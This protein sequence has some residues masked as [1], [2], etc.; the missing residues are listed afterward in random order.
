[1]SARQPLQ[2]HHKG[3]YTVF[4][5]I[6]LIHTT[7]KG[8]SIS[9]TLARKNLTQF[10]YKTG[11]Y[12]RI[13]FRP[14]ILLKMLFKR[15]KAFWKDEKILLLCETFTFPKLKTFRFFLQKSTSNV[16]KTFSWST[17]IWYAFYSKFTIFFQKNQKNSVRV[18]KLHSTCP[19][20]HFEDKDF[21]DFHNYFRTLSE[22]I[23]DFWQRLICRVVK[24]VLYVSRRTS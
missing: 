21:F 12:H 16:E 18:S 15:T 22:K 19:E 3:Q 2:N 11:G 5:D 17:V 7:Y 8:S 4:L 1:M 10:K 14:P 6:L 13:F 20:E 9:R 24:T 23:S